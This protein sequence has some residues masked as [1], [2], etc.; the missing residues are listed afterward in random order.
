MAQGS[1]HQGLVRSSNQDAFLVD[2]HARLW[3]VADGMGGHPG[4]DIASALVIETLAKL[5]PSLDRTSAMTE[6]MRKAAFTG[7]LHQAHGAI[8]AYVAVHPEYRNMGTTL[9]SA[10]AWNASPSHLL[11]ANVGDS[12]AYLVREG[13]I[14]QLTRDH[15]LVEDYIRLGYLTAAQ[16]ATHPERHVLTR[17]M[18]LGQAV[19]VD[20]FPTVLQHDDV[21]ILC[22]DG[23]TKMLNDQHILEVTRASQ[24]NPASLPQKLIQAA[25]ENG[26]VD[27]VTVVI[28][29]GTAEQEGN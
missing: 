11:I 28:C 10:H 17:A 26:G 1:T 4:G 9:V 23:L 14:R 8:L 29:T 25:L 27:N 21:V 3:A 18:G 15:T 16:A 6:E 7:M 24:G 20:L 13:S 2:N 12:R 19:T 22:S 5:A